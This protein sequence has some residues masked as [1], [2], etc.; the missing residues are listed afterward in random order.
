MPASLLERNSR[1]HC[2][3]ALG[4]PKAKWA[5]T[6][7]NAEVGGPQMALAAVTRGRELYRVVEHGGLKRHSLSNIGGGGESGDGQA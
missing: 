7:S 4:H 5:S 6:F 3:S 2:P 1:A